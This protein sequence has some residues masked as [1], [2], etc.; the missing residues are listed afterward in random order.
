MRQHLNVPMN[1]P[2]MITEAATGEF[3]QGV[4]V[5]YW[6]G[7]IDWK[8]LAT[9]CQF[10]YIRAGWGVTKDVRL[11][12]NIA[13]AIGVGM[14]FG[15]YHY[16]MPKIDVIEQADAF[17]EWTGKKDEAG[18]YKSFGVLEPALDCE[19]KGLPALGVSQAAYGGVIKSWLGLYE[20]FTLIEPIIYTSPGFWNERIGK[21]AWAKQYQLW[22]ANW[23]T[24]YVV[25]WDWVG[26]TPL[27]WQYAVRPDG[28]EWGMSGK[29]LDHDYF[30]GTME[31]FN[32]RYG[33][34]ITPPQPPP[35]PNEIIA[36]VAFN[37]RAMPN[38]LYTTPILGTTKSGSKWLVENQ[39][40][41]TK[42]RGYWYQIGRGA[43]LAGWLCG[44]LN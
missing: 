3:P 23:N 37:I 38:D 43:W 39:T 36:K 34:N 22:L 41:D 21:T 25:P 7:K 40:I 26:I 6:Q 11:D 2:N 13:G 29:G 30:I 42:G 31:A 12:E 9:K 5:S 24:T 19:E 35:C 44:I 4:D 16:F 17:I 14:P 15:N 20:T 1:L 27:F 33:T 18:I 10:V 32:T 28:Q 8:K